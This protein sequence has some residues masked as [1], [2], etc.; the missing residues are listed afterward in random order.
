MRPFD[1]ER[2]GSM[3]PVTRFFESLQKLANGEINRPS[4]SRFGDSGS[5]NPGAAPFRRQ[6]KDGGKDEKGRR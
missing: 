5:E 4:E 3:N 6:E 1:R 2:T